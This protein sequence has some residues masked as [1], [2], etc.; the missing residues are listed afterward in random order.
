ML[1]LVA[2]SPRE[3]HWVL[4]TSLMRTRWRY[5]TYVYESMV[6]ELLFIRGAYCADDLSYGWF[7]A[8]AA[9]GSRKMRSESSMDSAH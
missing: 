7:E 9:Q 1:Q 2:W 8:G 5:V 4:S 3:W 6:A